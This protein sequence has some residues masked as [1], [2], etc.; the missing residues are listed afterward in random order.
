VD[1]DQSR[2]VSANTDGALSAAI[3]AGAVALYLQAASDQAD[4]SAAS[5]QQAPVLLNWVSAGDDRVCSTCSDY[6]DGSPYTPEQVPDYPHSMC[7][8]SVDTVS[9]DDSFLA[10]LLAAD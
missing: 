2:S 9:E 1:G 10:A 7:R 3:L 5:A 4:A 6:E 8:C